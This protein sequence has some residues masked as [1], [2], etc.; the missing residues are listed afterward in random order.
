[1]EEQLLP[2]SHFKDLWLKGH[3]YWNKHHTDQ[4]GIPDVQ[5]YNG[6]SFDEIDLAGYSNHPE[7]GSELWPFGNYNLNGKKLSFKNTNFGNHNVS[8]KNTQLT[9][10]KLCFDSPSFSKNL[11]FDHATMDNAELKIKL[12]RSDGTD[13]R[14]LSLKRV[15]LINTSLYCDILEQS[16]PQPN[17]KYCLVIDLGETESPSNLHGRTNRGINLELHVVASTGVSVNAN[18]LHA[19]NVKI[20][21]QNAIA[22]HNI[23]D[24]RNAIINGA[25]VCTIQPVALNEYPNGIFTYMM[26]NIDFKD[27]VIFSVLGMA[28][29]IRSFTLQNSIFRN[30]LQINSKTTFGAVIDLVGTTF[31]RHVALDQVRC[32]LPRR[33][34]RITSEPNNIE[35]KW[36][37]LPWGLRLL[38]PF[39]FSMALNSD[40]AKRF[41]RLKEISENN[42]DHKRALEFKIQEMQ[43]AR[44]YE[45]PLSH[46]PLEFFYWLFSDYGRSVTRPILAGIACWIIFAAI[47]CKFPALP[48]HEVIVHSLAFSATQM[49]PLIP[50]FRV[51][52]AIGLSEQFT[53]QIHGLV[54]FFGWLQTI[55]STAF[56]FLIGL[57]LRNRFRI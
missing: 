23:L 32:I 46:L 55:L 40:E 36:R 8:F 38:Y 16:E 3:D 33:K 13:K 43:A 20:S 41:R 9:N 7:F 30:S 5:P 44:F 47:Y 11:F 54:Y 37:F 52:T 45:T 1:M 22:G 31:E 28:S 6:L 35:L 53:G 27:T 10:T 2:F 51:E 56:I 57:A 25:F 17:N 4:T 24:F 48:L 49:F 34:Q 15:C 50:V 26:E 18:K 19:N 42:R 12:Q 21:Y 29:Q 14:I 39:R